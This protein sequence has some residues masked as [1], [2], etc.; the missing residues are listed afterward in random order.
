MSGLL[1]SRPATLLYSYQRR[2]HYPAITHISI[3]SYNKNCK[4]VYMIGIIFKLYNL[5][6]FLILHH[7]ALSLMSWEIR[8]ILLHLMTDILK[9]IIFLVGIQYYKS[10]KNESESVVSFTDHMPV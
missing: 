1:M 5:K 3:M 7:E 2:T 9:S 10:A 4:T 8:E 6:Q